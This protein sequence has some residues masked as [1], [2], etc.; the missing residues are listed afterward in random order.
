MKVTF[1]ISIGGVDRKYAYNLVEKFKS[2]TNK[3]FKLILQDNDDSGVDQKLFNECKSTENYLYDKFV[4]TGLSESR[5]RCA[6]LA[7]TDYVHYLDDDIQIKEDFSTSVLNSLSENDTALVISGKTLP[8]WESD[9]PD[10][11]S[12][13]I[14]QMFS[15]VDFGAS[16]LKF[17][18]K[19]FSWLAGVNFIVKRDALLNFG[20][21]PLRLGRSCFDKSLLSN[22]E[23][24]LVQNIWKNGGEIIYDP[25][26]LVEH[27][28]K[29][30]QTTRDWVS[31]RVAWQAVSDF[32]SGEEWYSELENEEVLI[33]DSCFSIYN[34]EDFNFENY[35]TKVKFLCYKMLEGKV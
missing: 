17:K 1:C 9:R 12:D 10:W 26:V 19:E 18:E 25:N 33:K 7:D 11:L 16:K 27:Y 35:L 13:N 28:I 24:F 2:Q 30:Y 6:L 4:C 31:K 32:L 5:N 8:K 29:E 20:G 34:Q 3:N 21:F 22:E 15:I 23:N 14:L